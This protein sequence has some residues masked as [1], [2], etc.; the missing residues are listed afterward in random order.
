MSRG[1]KIALIVAGVVLL[2]AFMAFSWLRGGYDSVVA[3]DENVKGSWAQVENQLKRRYDLIPN[4]VQTVQ[5]YAKHEKEL[6]ENIAN[7]RTKYFQAKGAK[8]KIKASNQLEGFLSRLLVL[9]E[10]YPQLKAN[11]GFLKLQDTLEGTENRIAVE[12]KRYNDSVQ[13][14]NTFIRTFFGRFFATFADVSSA[15]Y[16]EIPEAEQAVPKVKF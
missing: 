14:L 13:L 8:G 15:E 12:R 2:F 4:L 11:E 5:G 16:Y 7:A 6:F 10:A 9:K 3:M 1:L